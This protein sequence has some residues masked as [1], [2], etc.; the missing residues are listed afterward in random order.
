MVSC[1]Y[2]WDLFQNVFWT[3]AKWHASVG[4]LKWD[5]GESTSKLV[6][7]S[8]ANWHVGETTGYQ[9]TSQLNSCVE[10]QA[11]VFP[12]QHY[13]VFCKSTR[14]PP[15]CNFRVKLWIFFL[16]FIFLPRFAVTTFSS[17][18]SWIRRSIYDPFC[19]YFMPEVIVKL[20]RRRK[21]YF[22]TLTWSAFLYI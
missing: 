21:G 8:L 6:K 2:I 5:V 15:L 22:V 7:R 13:Q 9:D 20:M 18:M 4:E 3:L 12:T 14:K 1:E 19:P 17:L 11:G 10:S 16:F